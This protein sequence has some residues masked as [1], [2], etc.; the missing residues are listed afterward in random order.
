MSLELRRRAELSAEQIAKLEGALAAFYRNP[1]PSYYA[2]ADQSSGAYTP[3]ERPFHCDL[4]Q[5]VT[6]GMSVLELGC[7]TAHLCA[8]VAERGGTY[9]GIDYGEELLAQNRKRF[10]RARFLQVGTPLPE[11]FDLVASLYA[12]EHVVDPPA[13]LERMWRCCRPGGLIAI[14]CPEFIEGPGLA[15]SVFYGRT[16]RRFREKIRTFNLLDALQHLVELKMLGP[17]WK[18]RVRRSAPGSFWINL[19]PAALNGG[20]YVIDADAVHLVGLRELAWYFRERR[21]E[22]I[23]SSAEMTAVSSDVRRYNC[24]VLVKKPASGPP[25]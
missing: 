3:A 5:Q 14:I 24:Y 10:P 18:G 16:P 21:A 1:P 23:R 13:Y 7:G 22:I 6:P 25:S 12:I 8:Y 4:V 20:A 19:Q 15:P 9:T 11:P 17:R 2:I